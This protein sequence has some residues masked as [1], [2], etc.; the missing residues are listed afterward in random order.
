MSP[1]TVPPVISMTLLPLPRVMAM[2]LPALMSPLLRT[3]MLASAPRMPGPVAVVMVPL[4]I[5]SVLP[6]SFD[7]MPLR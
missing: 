2:P 6:V 5:M 7:L 4:L 3:V 1:V